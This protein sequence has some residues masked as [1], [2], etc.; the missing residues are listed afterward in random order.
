MNKSILIPAE[1]LKHNI[2]KKKLLNDNVNSNLLRLNGLIESS[3]KDNKDTLITRLPIAFNIPENFNE[4]E[5]QLEVYYSLI[6]IL[7]FKGYIVR[8]RIEKDKTTIKITWKTNDD[9]DLDKMQ[10]KMKV[11][12]F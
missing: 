1:R 6:D 2:L 4:K 3:H 10:K 5:F 8:I 12:S 11:I 7:E 9:S